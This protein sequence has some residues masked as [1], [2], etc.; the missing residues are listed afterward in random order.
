[1]F[2]INAQTQD[3]AY[4]RSLMSVKASTAFR[5]APKENRVPEWKTGDAIFMSG[6]GEVAA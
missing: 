4:T 6:G 1:M 2:L 5:S 3:R